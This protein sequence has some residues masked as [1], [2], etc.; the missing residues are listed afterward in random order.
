VSLGPQNVEGLFFLDASILDNGLLKFSSNAG[1]DLNH[2]CDASSRRA[3][4]RVVVYGAWLGLW[5]VVE[6]VTRPIY[7]ISAESTVNHSGSSSHLYSTPDG[8]DHLSRTFTVASFEMSTVARPPLPTSDKLEVETV[9]RV[10]VC[11]EI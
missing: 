1:I 6:F 11:S 10:R 7:A 2:G 4:S 5:P 8:L 3:S 9:I